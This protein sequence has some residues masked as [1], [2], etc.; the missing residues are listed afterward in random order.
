[1]KKKE[2]EKILYFPVIVH[3]RYNTWVTRERDDSD[4]WDNDDTSTDVTVLGVETEK[5][6]REST[7]Y[8]DIVV[9]FEVVPG[10]DYYLVYVTYS[11]GDS[12]HHEEGEVNYVELFETR[13]KAEK[14]AQIINV[15]YSFSGNE[16]RWSDKGTKAPKGY[17]EH[18]LT[19][20]NEEGREMKLYVNW[21]GYFERM[22][23]V[24]VQKVQHMSMADNGRIRYRY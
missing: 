23:C 17:S 1:M 24:T 3:S 15:H 19:Y 6:R 14:L 8:R 18:E 12:F 10:K 5:E 7:M 9:P 16:Q 11:T 22:T 4:E 21:T 13:E 20:H 2:K